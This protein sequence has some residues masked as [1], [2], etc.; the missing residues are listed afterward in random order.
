MNLQDQIASTPK[1]NRRKRTKKTSRMLLVDPGK[2]L[3]GQF[4]RVFADKHYNLILDRSLEHAFER[5]EFETFEIL[6]ISSSA[7]KEDELSGIEILEVI[8]EKCAATQILF[9]A[10][11]KEISLAFSALKSG[12]YQ[13]GVLPIADDELRLL[14]ETALEQQPDYAPNLLLKAERQKTSFEDMIGGSPCMRDIYRQIR[15]AAMADMPILITGETGTGKDLVAR[16][17]HQLSD[18]KEKSFIPIHLGSL[19]Q[20]LVASEL[21]GH[22]KG[23]FTGAW[24]RYKGTFER[25]HGGTVFLD[26]VGTIDE[27]DQ[28]S[29]LRLLEEKRFSRLGNS[30]SIRVNVRIIAA[31][32]EDLALAVENGTFREDL[33]YRLEVFRIE[34]PPVKERTGDTSL[35]VNHFLNRF[36]EDYNRNIIGISP[37]CITYLESYDWP[38]NVREIKNIIHRAVVM[39]HGETLL[40]KHLPDRIIRG[41]LKRPNIKF[42]VGTPLFEIEREVIIQ[43]LKWSNNNRKKTAET[44]GISRK[45]LYNKLERHQIK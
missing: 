6:V 9:L 37:E 44:L 3:F 25:A 31:T 17:I 30:G 34:L 39:C 28:V 13:Y 20:D 15:Q 42:P 12:S 21:F 23:A 45:A 27:K 4:N 5:F 14:I 35:L 8:S 11:P 10:F 1:K 32:N 40:L 7:L 33:F 29:L 2:E 24:K 26:E 41:R 16:A 38:G 43:T 19:P 36:N 18:R 22:E